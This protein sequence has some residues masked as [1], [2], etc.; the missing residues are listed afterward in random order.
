MSPK[1]VVGAAWQ[2]SI[3][4]LT[5]AYTIMLGRERFSYRK[6]AGFVV[7]S[8]GAAVV[9]AGSGG[10]GGG[11]GGAAHNALLGNLCFFVNTNCLALYGISTQPLMRAHPR[12]ALTITTCS[13]VVCALAM[14]APL[15]LTAASP[16]LHA[17]VC[18]ACVASGTD[19][20]VPD[21]AIFGLCYM[22]VVFSFG[23]YG[24]INWANTFI[25]TSKINAYI[26]LQPMF[27]AVT[28]ALLL[29]AGF[30][31]R[32]PRAPLTMPN[33]ATAAG[34]VGI[35]I[36]LALVLAEDFAGGRRA[37]VGGGGVAAPGPR[38]AGLA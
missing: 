6:A 37:I 23:A 28:V 4:I 29:Q 20:A 10:G 30:N 35:L 8:A 24:C 22:I 25:D 3:P 36:G 9:V 13:F 1:A 5:S 27:A 7:A 12:S 18:P 34:G 31:E 11:G 38:R 21:S 19:W 2:C 33:A 15:G 14:C 16:A 26:S 32:H 17:L